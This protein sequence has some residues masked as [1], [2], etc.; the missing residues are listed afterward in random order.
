MG[1]KLKLV[2]ILAVLAGAGYVGYRVFFQGDRIEDVGKD[3]EDAVNI[4]P[5]V[6]ANA[7]FAASEW[8]TAL[9]HYEEALER[10]NDPDAGE[11]DRLNDEQLRNCYRNIA[12]ARYRLAEL[13]EWDKH[14]C[15]EA[16]GALN[17]YLDTYDVSGEEKDG[18][19]NKI[20]KLKTMS[21]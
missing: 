17:Y 7:A 20:N 21:R 9:E 8:D 6:K 15:S 11:D 4:S 19:M 1:E 3:I 18:L 2:I 5:I 14:T 12:L 13:S 10:H 16:V